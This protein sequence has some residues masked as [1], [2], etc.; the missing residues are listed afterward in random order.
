MTFYPR[1]LFRLAVP[2]LLVVVALW[3]QGYLQRSGSNL[4]VTLSIFPYFLA[5][6]SLFVAYQFGQSRAFVAA[7]AIAA[8][9]W[10]V[11]QQ[12]QVSLAQEA[13]AAAY[14]GLCVAVP[15]CALFIC[16]VPERGLLSRMGLAVV[17]VFVA[18]MTLLYLLPRSGVVD[19]LALPAWQPWAFDTMVLSQNAIYLQSL[20]VLAAILMLCVRDTDFDAALVGCLLA[21]CSGLAL[22]HLSG[23]SFAMFSAAGLCLLFGQLRSSY[24]MAYRDELTGVLG[25]RALNEHL[26]RLGRRY[27]IAMVDVDHFKRLN[28]KHG[29][30]VGDEVLKLVASR[31]RSVGSGGTVYRYGGEEF[32]IVFPRKTAED[33]V[34]PME[35]VREDIA[36]YRMALRDR[37][38][39][40]LKAKEGVGRRG[41]TRVGK[42]QV[43]VTISA[44]IAERSPDCSDPQAVI[45][46]ADARLY[47]AKKSGRNRVAA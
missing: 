23:I 6:L 15:V 32:S 16:L 24:S 31:L 44:G 27:T 26:K 42:S 46:Q 9:Y 43:S 37:T 8:A 3:G 14:L 4:A 18:T 35:R 19:W 29:H 22:L 20:S 41:A 39:R 5:A 12:L 2:L 34:E 10:V 33:C 1:A 17:V 30:D 7:L 28:D 21:L 36:A 40:P 47:K 38:V 45:S 13:A 11:Q 25:R